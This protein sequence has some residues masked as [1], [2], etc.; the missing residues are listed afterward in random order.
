MEVSKHTAGSFCWI[1]LGTTDQPSA[2]QFY[3]QL[4][5]W[6]I[7]D[8]PMG[9]DSFYTMLQKNGKDVSALYQLSPEQKSQGIP[10]HWML[11]IAVE[12]ADEIA[13]AVTAAGGKVMAEPF[14]V[15]DVGRMSIVQD[16]T[17]A[18]FALWQPKNHIGV[19]LHNEDNTLCWQELVTRDPA[20]AKK[21][22]TKVFG[23]NDVTKEYGPTQYTEYYIGDP[24]DQKSTGGMLKM[25]EERG[26]VPSHWMAYFAV[27]DCEA[28]VEKAKSLGANIFVPPTD[29]PGVG[30]FAMIAD[31]QGA[32]FS[33]IKLNYPT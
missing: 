31:P 32:L 28:A 19:Q 15:F 18:T 27:N 5:G 30:R 14:D 6:N 2:K 20:A 24:K 9:P 22:Y 23:W 29:V 8:V 17:G 12:S 13:K 7:N 3:S 11:Y 4:F 1:E 25:T 16:P 33:V 21:F 26:D 10:P